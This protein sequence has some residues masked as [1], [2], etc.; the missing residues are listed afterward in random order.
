MDKISFL[1][2]TTSIRKLSQDQYLR[3]KSTTNDPP[4]SYLLLSFLFALADKIVTVE[5]G[6]LAKWRSRLVH[7]FQ[8]NDQLWVS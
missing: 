7:G 6:N 5:T 8:E 4:N 3:L 1:S 2:N